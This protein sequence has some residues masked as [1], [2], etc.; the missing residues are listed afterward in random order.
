MPGAQMWGCLDSLILGRIKSFME[1]PRESKH[2]AILAV[3]A[4]CY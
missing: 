4:K 1:F 2:L 3:E